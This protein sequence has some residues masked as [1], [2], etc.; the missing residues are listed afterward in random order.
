MSSYEALY[1][2]PIDR[3]DFDLVRQFVLNA[4][5]ADLFT[6][7]VTFE[8]KERRHSTNVAEAVVALSNTDGGI[9]LVG[10]RDTG[11]VG[12]GRIIGL[13]RP[14]GYADVE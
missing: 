14:L 6:E 13:C 11:V 4:E 8:A 1:R 10:V 2:G 5:E 9:V 3:I 7:S 12:E